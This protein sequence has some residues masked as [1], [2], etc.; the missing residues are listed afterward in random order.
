MNFMV[1]PSKSFLFDVLEKRLSLLDGEVGLDA[2]SADFKNRRMFKTKKYFGLDI[3]LVSLKEGLAKYQTDE[4]TFG[5]CGNLVNLAA[6]PVDS[7]DVIV[8]TN[9]LY[10]LS[11]DQRMVAINNLI[12]LTAPNGYFFCELSIDPSLAQI[13]GLFK[14]NFKNVRIIYYKNIFSLAYEKIFEKDGYLGSHPIAGRK[15]FR[16]LAWLISRVEFVTQFF[17]WF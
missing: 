17:P 8:S 3:N 4:V 9:T 12:K 13:I 6:L 7:V 5:L 10:R 1:R 15:P 16:L 14:S 11:A 2:A